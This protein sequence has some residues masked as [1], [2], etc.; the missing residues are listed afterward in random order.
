MPVYICID[1][2][3]DN[4]S[5][6]SLI[7]AYFWR[8][9]VNVT[10]SRDVLVAVR[11]Y[12]RL[13]SVSTSTV[14]NW[15]EKITTNLSGRL[16]SSYGI[17]LDGDLH[18]LSSS[19]ESFSTIKYA[20]LFFSIDLSVVSGME[21]VDLLETQ[22][23]WVLD[24]FDVVVSIL[25]SE[26]EVQLRKT[27]AQINPEMFLATDVFP[28]ASEWATETKI[29][30]SRLVLSRSSLKS[31]ETKSYWKTSR[32]DEE[33][34]H[35]CLN[36]SHRKELIKNEG[37]HVFLSRRFSVGRRSHLLIEFLVAFVTLTS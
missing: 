10:V 17:L 30:R 14:W 9:V 4:C 28:F 11:C 36:D 27:D 31:H 22:T 33:Q 7:W 24:L 19:S 1:I 20:Q 37:N 8:A 12:L 6:L 13:K 18:N 2:L 32:H 16:H 29:I 23:D 34:R 21:G 15:R 5:S 35:S 26:K 3:I 25:S